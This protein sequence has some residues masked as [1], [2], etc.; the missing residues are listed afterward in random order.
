M[1]RTFL[2]SAGT[3]LGLLWAIWGGA[4]PAYA[5]DATVSVWNV[6]PPFGFNPDASVAD[7]GGLTGHVNTAAN[8]LT[9][10]TMMDNDTMPGG[11]CGVIFWNPKTNMFV[12]Y[13]FG[14]GFAD[15][16]DINVTAPPL[17]G[18]PGT[19]FGTPTFGPGDTWM[20]ISGSPPLSVNLKGTNHFRSWSVSSVAGVKVDQSSGLIFFADSSGGSINRF[21][22]ST[23]TTTT[24]FVGGSPSYLTQDAMGNVF[25]TVA[26]ATVGGG[27]AADKIVELTPS[28]GAV[29][30]W[31][32]P[33]GGL[34]AGGPA[35]NGRAVNGIATDTAGN[36]WSDESASSEVGRL[37]PAT[38]EF[39]KYQQ[40]GF[41][42]A[43]QQIA[44]TGSGSTLQSFFTE[45][46]AGVDLAGAVSV[47]T[48]SAAVPETSP[49]PVVT[50]F[51]G[52]LT[53]GPSTPSFTDF[54]ET[55]TTATITPL[56]ATVTAHSS[57][58]IDRFPMPTPTGGSATNPNVPSGMTGVALP[59][60]VFG[61]YQDTNF[62]SNSAVFAVNSAAI[63]APPPGTCTSGDA[64][65][66]NEVFHAPG[67]LTFDVSSPTRVMSSITLAASSNIA[68][69]TMPTIAAGGHSATGGS[70]VKADNTKKATFTL[71]ITFV[72][73]AFAC[74]IDPTIKKGHKEHKDRDRFLDNE[75]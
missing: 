54:I 8:P 10:A 33:G 70:L 15:G 21:N 2:A 29:K 16:I 30:A 19:V 36:I 72:T 26:L 22:P 35:A 13:G 32:I 47:L 53:G 74:T 67:T 44:S 56:T 43:P 71:Q 48:Q 1:K 58:G 69:S 42:K 61:S 37:N 64:V 40:P 9:I 20:G 11:P 55:A 66:M 41:T 23:N 63:I 68:S 51:T 60:T 49:C 75:K 5:V 14:G 3:A 27:A 18:T 34:A 65:L 50:P 73:P 31:T 24:W 57:L 46:G 6:T 17:T 25:A 38:G 45:A 12:G 62:A 28:T 52:T 4:Q 39:C 59:G 7:I